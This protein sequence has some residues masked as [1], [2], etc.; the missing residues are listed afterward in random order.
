M[1]TRSSAII[2]QPVVGDAALTHLSHS[3][4]RLPVAVSLAGSFRFTTEDFIMGQR[5]F[6]SF[7]KAIKR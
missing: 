1:F 6:L 2:N 5:S 7:Y 4:K 3:Q